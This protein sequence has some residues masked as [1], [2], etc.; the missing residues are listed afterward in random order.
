MEMSLHPSEEA[1]GIDGRY[2]WALPLPAARRPARQLS[3]VWYFALPLT[4]A[5]RG[6]ASGGGADIEGVDGQERYRNEGCVYPHAALVEM[7][8]YQHRCFP[9]MT[10][11]YIDMSHVQW[12]EVQAMIESDPPE[13]AALSAYTA[14]ALW[15]FIVAAEVKRVN[16]DAVVVFGTTMP[17]SCTGRSSPVST[18]AVSSTTSV[19]ATTARSP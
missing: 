10:A 14:T 2:Q 6:G 3:S 7:M 19:P 17:E 16:P 18:A 9:G 8:T 11:R 4:S 5:H 15:A 1:V 12:P 13:V